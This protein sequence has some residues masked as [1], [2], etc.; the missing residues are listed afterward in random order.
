MMT[1]VPHLFQLPSTS[2]SEHNKCNG[3]KNIACHMSLLLDTGQAGLGE[4]ICA[5]IYCT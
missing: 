4:D 2:L 3:L 1:Y 5:I